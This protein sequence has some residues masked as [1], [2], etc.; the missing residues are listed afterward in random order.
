MRRRCSSLRLLR[1]P[2]VFISELLSPSGHRYHHAS[3]S[4]HGAS[5]Q[6]LTGKF[7]V[8]ILFKVFVLHVMI[9]YSNAYYRVSDEA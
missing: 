8:S 4:L 5:E 6:Q 3:S 9:S 7:R 2:R 1:V